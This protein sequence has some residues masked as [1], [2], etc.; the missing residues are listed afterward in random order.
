[1]IYLSTETE[2]WEGGGYRQVAP[3]E[4]QQV[5]RAAHS[6]W[7]RN[8]NKSYQMIAV[9]TWSAMLSETT[10]WQ[11]YILI[12]YSTVPIIFQ[13]NVTTSIVNLHSITFFA[14]P[15]LRPADGS[16]LRYSAISIFFLCTVR[17][18]LRKCDNFIF[19]FS[20]TSESGNGSNFYQN[21]TGNKR[22][23]GSIY[24]H[25]LPLCKIH[26]HE[27]F[28]LWFF[29]RS[30]HLATWF[31]LYYIFWNKT[32]IRRY[33]YLWRAGYTPGDCLT[34]WVY[35]TTCCTVPVYKLLFI[36][37]NKP[38]LSYL[39]LCLL[40]QL[41]PWSGCTLCIVHCTF[42]HSHSHAVSRLKA[43]M[44]V[45]ATPGSP[46]RRGR[47]PGS[48][49]GGLAATK[50]VLFSDL[51]VSSPSS[52]PTPPRDGPGTVFLPDEEVVARPGP[53]ALS[54]PP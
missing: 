1:L 43:C 33:I 7:L 3:W 19:I 38:V 47:P 21:G 17:T 31:Y 9:K 25:E 49:P 44:A 54:Q 22:I 24:L 36:R 41:W 42:V 18:N 8:Q 30:T 45:D 40:P 35:S 2:A 53:A 34:S 16:T 20:F 28:S 11:W 15:G 51:L 46:H 5:A 4:N 6:E 29:I 26:W 39:S 23:A 12:T 27:I 32:R 14:N 50:R 37:Q 10:W 48:R 52:S 13:K